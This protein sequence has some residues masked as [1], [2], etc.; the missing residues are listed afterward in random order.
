[1]LLLGFACVLSACTQR[2]QVESQGRVSI[3]ADTRPK[4]VLI[5]AGDLGCSDLDVFGSEN[6]KGYVAVEFA[7]LSPT[8]EA[9]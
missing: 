7:A 3:P 6:I 5:V 8:I 9:A 4:F 2:D 1:M